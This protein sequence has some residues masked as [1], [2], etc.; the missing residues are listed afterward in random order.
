VL[1]NATIIIFI[2]IKHVEKTDAIHGPLTGGSQ[3]TLHAQ[4]ARRVGVNHVHLAHVPLDPTN[5][6]NCN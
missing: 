1:L 6:H 3:P 4:T 5:P 2:S